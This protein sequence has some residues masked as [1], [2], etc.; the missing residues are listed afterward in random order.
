M[1]DLAELVKNGY[2]FRAV[3][4]QICERSASMTRNSILSF[5]DASIADELDRRVTMD[6]QIGKTVLSKY[7]AYRGLMLSSCHCIEEY[8]PKIVIVPDCY[9][10]IP[11]QH[12]KYV[13]DDN[14]EFTDK[15]GNRRKW[16]QKAIASKTTDIKINVFDGCGIHHP[17]ISEKME[18]MIGSD[19]LMTSILWRAPYIKGVT[20]EMDYESF[21]AEHGITEI[22]DVWGVK[23]DFS[24]PMIIMSESMYKGK[25]YFQQYSD[26]RDWEEYWNRFKKYGHCIGVAKWN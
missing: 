8:I 23:H 3:S 12:I 7:Y 13:Y 4:F 1:D 22:T 5:V 11:D 21:F 16:T 15:N 20:H 10:I 9:R 6:I 25:K 2:R 24:E 14:T 19:T 26:S 18:K 17:A